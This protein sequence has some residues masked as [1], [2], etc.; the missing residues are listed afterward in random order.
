[1]DFFDHSMKTARECGSYRAIAEMMSD[2]IRT[3]SAAQAGSIEAEFA[4]MSLV[5]LA[6]QLEETV[7]NYKKE[8]DTVA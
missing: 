3:L 2:R 5:S 7:E 6:Q 8:V 1:M 4:M